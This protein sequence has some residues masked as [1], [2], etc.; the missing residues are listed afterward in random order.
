MNFF[1]LLLFCLGWPAIGQRRT[2]RAER[3]LRADRRI[4]RAMLCPCDVRTS[5]CRLGHG[6]GALP[7]HWS[8]SVAS[9]RSGNDPSSIDL[10]QKSIL[11]FAAHPVQPLFGAFGPFLIRL[12]NSLEF[13]NSSSAA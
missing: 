8:S 7:L 11:D 3:L 5:T 1:G 6:F 4:A 12:P 9:R 2:T 10:F 13:R